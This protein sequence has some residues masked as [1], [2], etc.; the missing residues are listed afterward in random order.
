MFLYLR[1]SSEARLA[2]GTGSKSV[3]NLHQRRV[4]NNVSS[5]ATNAAYTHLW[6][7]S[8]G[9]GRTHCFQY[10]CVIIWKFL[11]RSRVQLTCF[12]LFQNKYKEDGRRSLSQS[13]YSQLPETA[14]TQFAKTVSGLQ[15]EVRRR[16]TSCCSSAT[17]FFCLQSKL[18]NMIKSSIH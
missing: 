11:P 18:H 5:V 7:L 3:C 17:T 4:G 16:I 9:A 14:E 6:R 8:G 15:S 13:F 2:S 12:R 1:R 10:V